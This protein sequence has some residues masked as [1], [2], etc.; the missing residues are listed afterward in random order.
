MFICDI[1]VFNRYGKIKL[2]QMLAPVSLDWRQLVVLFVLEQRPGISQAKLKPF[3]Q[4][5][6]ANVTKL[7]QA[8]E[9]EKLI[10]RTPD[11]KDQRNKLCFLTEAGEEQLPALHRILSE[12][13]SACFAGLT[14]A[15]REELERLNAI[16]IKNLVGEWSQDN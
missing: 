1:S 6:K 7:L 15:E 8:M 4:T 16:I 3:L 14:A 12:W 9:H 2:D 13:E 5:D 10:H 11:E